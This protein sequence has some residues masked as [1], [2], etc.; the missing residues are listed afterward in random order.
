MIPLREVMLIWFHRI[1]VFDEILLPNIFPLIS[2][3]YQELKTVLED[4]V[5]DVQL[6]LSSNSNIS[7]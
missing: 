4:E 6:I 7:R 2:K 3:V 1:R 5:D